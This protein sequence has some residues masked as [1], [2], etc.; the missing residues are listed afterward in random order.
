MNGIFYF[1][2]LGAVLCIVVN[3]IISFGRL[4]SKQFANRCFEQFHKFRI[5]TL[6]P[7]L[8]ISTTS[9]IIHSQFNLISPKLPV[10]RLNNMNASWMLL[11]K[12]PSRWRIWRHCGPS[13][14][15]DSAQMLRIGKTAVI[16]KQPPAL[17]KLKRFVF[18]YF[19]EKIR[20]GRTLQWHCNISVWI[21]LV[22]IWSNRHAHTFWLESTWE[23]RR[24]KISISN[25][26]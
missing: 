12:C 15:S 10:L 9:Q 8:A 22:A 7:V 17:C 6:H 25:C 14:R 21:N 11:A 20:C 1:V 24:E 18:C 4:K 13:A 19:I 23:W 3:I 26:V 16:L 5:S 2:L